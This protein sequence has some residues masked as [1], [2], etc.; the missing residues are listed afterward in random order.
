MNRLTDKVALITGAASGIGLATALRFAEE[1]ATVVL[2]DRAA[3]RLA[4]ALSAL[5]QVN[6]GHM[7]IAF[8]VTLEQDWQ[9]A[10][11]RIEQSF[12]RLDILFNNA[13][14]GR[15]CPI[16]ET[17]LES[18]RAIMAVNL[19]SVFLGTKHALPLLAKSGK[20]AI[21]NM[22]SIRGMVAGA[23]SGAYSAAKA[24]V[25]LFSKVTALECA[26]AGNGVRVNSVHPGHVETPLTAAAYANPELARE[27]LAH[28]PMGRFAQAREIAQAVVF[29]ASDEASY[30]TGAEVTIDGGVTAL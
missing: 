18:W 7:A 9:A 28:T 10:I 8:D 17:T 24:G 4:D 27:F 13:G 26:E 5:E 23:N 19:D 21:V 20:G 15:F 30:M 22:S 1:G 12:G 2:G 6:P 11:T 25:R 3:D 14:F 16:E 29:M